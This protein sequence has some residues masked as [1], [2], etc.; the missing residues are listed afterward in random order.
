MVKN[1]IHHCTKCCKRYGLPPQHLEIWKW[2]GA[3]QVFFF[4]ERPI[5]CFTVVHMLLKSLWQFLLTHKNITRDTI[6]W[7][8]LDMVTFWNAVD[9]HHQTK[10]EIRNILSHLRTYLLT[11]WNRVLLEKVTGSQLAKNFPVFYN[12]R[13]LIAAFTSDRHVSLS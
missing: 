2:K 7:D 11:P 10:A 1:K 13:R 5:N 4:S 12:G 8:I 6:I 9:R 3:C